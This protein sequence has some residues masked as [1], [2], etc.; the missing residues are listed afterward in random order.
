MST[1]EMIKQART[2]KN[3]SQEEL[4]NRLGVSRQA[5]SK[6]ES[7]K[8][9]PIGVNKECIN[10]ILEISL[11]L[12]YN[13][14]DNQ[15]N[16]YKGAMI[17][18]WILV[19]VLLVLL[20]ISLIYIFTRLN[21]VSPETD[22]KKAEM[23]LEEQIRSELCNKYQLDK[24]TVNVNVFSSEEGTDIATI[25]IMDDKITI[26]SDIVNSIKEYVSNNSI[27][28]FENVEIVFE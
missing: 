15:S 27:I 20:S 13:D 11:E 4:A 8:S 23:L 28:K 14:A 25:V 5:V 7:D 12:E 3:M 19:G 1:G 2:K 10:S 22:N 18:G 24:N 16:K 26:Q 9:V 21:N 17:A 6:W